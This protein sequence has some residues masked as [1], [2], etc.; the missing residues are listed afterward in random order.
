MD[1]T[2]IQKA[3]SSEVLAQVYQELNNRRNFLIDRGDEMRQFT[4]GV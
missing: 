2:R 1:C 4:E 3:C